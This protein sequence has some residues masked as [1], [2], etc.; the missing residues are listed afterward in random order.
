MS[1]VL[2]FALLFSSV[3]HAEHFDLTLDTTEQ[4]CH[5][6]QF[7]SDVPE[8]NIEISQSL[9]SSYLAYSSRFFELVSHSNYVLIPQLRAPPVKN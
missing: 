7:T 2:S 5:L 4:H 8:N 9:T 3:S 1:V 6:C